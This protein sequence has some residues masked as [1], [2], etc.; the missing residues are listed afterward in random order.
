M[1]VSSNPPANG[2]VA[3]MRKVYNPI[4]FGKG[5]N[6]VLWFIFA[7]AMMGFSLSRSMYLN[8]NGVFCGPAGGSSNHAASGEC[9]RYSTKELYKI[10]IQMHLYTVIPAGFLVCFQFVPVIRHKAILFHRMNGYV[11]LLLSLVST[12]GA[13]IIL[14]A[15]FG[16]GIEIQA[17]FGA[18]GILF[19]GSMAISYYNVKRLQLEQHRAWMLRAWFYVCLP[20]PLKS[21]TWC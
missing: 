7:G 19:L 2:F 13:Y 1:V 11:V 21:T 20:V 6:F 12:A 3:T 14:P 17:A 8:F 16:G 9:W 5:Y 4:G 18:I 15:S 10:G